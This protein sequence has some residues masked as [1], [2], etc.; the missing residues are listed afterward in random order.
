MSVIGKFDSFALRNVSNLELLH[1]QNIEVIDVVT[2]H[3]SINVNKVKH[4]SININF[5]K[6]EQISYV[7]AVFF[8]ILDLYQNISQNIWQI[9]F[10]RF[11]SSHHKCSMKK[12][13]LRNFTKF[14]R[15]HLCQS[16]FFNKVATLRPTTLLKKGLWHRCFPVNFVKFLKAP[17]LQNTSGRLFLQIWSSRIFC[18]FAS[19]AHFH[20][21]CLF[22]SLKAEF[23]RYKSALTKLILNF[24]SVIHGLKQTSFW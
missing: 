22:R 5:V 14:T 18:A 23:L 21:S 6:L 7:V 1:P 3:Q 9:P 24:F 12:G 16:L 4:S 17:F 20:K 19:L 15:K 2:L 13:V 11:R 10:G 8:G